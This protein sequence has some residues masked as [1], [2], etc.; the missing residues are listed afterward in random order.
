M[1]GG[2]VGRTIKLP[3]LPSESSGLL[4]ES[5]LSITFDHPIVAR[6]GNEQVSLG[7][8]RDSGGMREKGRA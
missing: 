8:N 7:A 6:V 2:D 1:V 5:S 3:F 4:D